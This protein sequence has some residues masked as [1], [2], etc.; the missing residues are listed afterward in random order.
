MSNHTGDQ[1]PRVGVILAG[2]QSRRM[3]VDKA[4]VLLAGRRLIDH[5]EARLAP[6]VDHIVISGRSDYG[7]GHSVVPDRADGPTGPAA[8]LWAAAHWLRSQQP[9]VTRFLTVPVDGPFLP[10]DLYDVLAATGP[11]AVAVSKS[12]SGTGLY[13]HATFGLW[14]IPRVLEELADVGTGKG[15][16]LHGLARASAASEVAFPPH[17]LFNINTQDDLAEAEI[18]FRNSA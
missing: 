16:S 18:L 9:S 6:Q 1:A 7:T 12:D 11:C 13:R 4:S 8:G 2:G 17:L 10:Y 15:P 5:V 3:S 14:P